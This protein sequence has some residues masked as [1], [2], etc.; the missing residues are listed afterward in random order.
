MPKALISNNSLPTPIRTVRNIGTV[1][2]VKL[3]LL[4]SE[5][6]QDNTPGPEAR[7]IPYMFG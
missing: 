7:N 1:V 5:K 2:K 4:E 6:N 3:V